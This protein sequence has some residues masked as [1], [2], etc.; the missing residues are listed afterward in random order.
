MNIRVIHQLSL[1]GIGGVQQSFVP[2][3]KM[4]LKRSEFKHLVYGMH[5]LDS[6]YRK[7]EPYIVDPKNGTIC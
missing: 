3:L 6:Y 2:Y 5:H 7:I 1:V 4:A